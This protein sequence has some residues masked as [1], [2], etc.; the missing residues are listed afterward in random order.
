M[1]KPE[2][3]FWRYAHSLAIQAP[4]GSWT[5]Y[6]EIQRQYDRAF[7]DSHWQHREAD[8]SRIAKLVGV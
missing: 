4:R 8:M 5:T 1:N 7:P 3:Y 2:D 6:N